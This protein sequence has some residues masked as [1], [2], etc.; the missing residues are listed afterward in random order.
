MKI[1]ILSRGPQLYST[2]SLV[3]A[4]F[5]KGHYVRVVD[6][7]ECN[8][9]LNKNNP[10][11]VY[12]SA[13]LKDID[14]IIPRI[15]NSGTFYGASV[16]QQFEMQD[17]YT[18]LTTDALLKARSKLRSMQLMSSC[19]IDMPRTILTNPLMDTGSI[20]NTIGVP[21]IIKLLSGT[22]GLGVILAESKK[23]GESVI[24][25]FHKLKE[26][27]IV[28]EFIKESKGSDIRAFVVDGKVV[29]AMKRQ[30]LPGEFRSNLH[31]GG[32]SE[33]ITL[34]E[35]EEWT[36]L[37]AVEILGLQ[38][39]GVD[40]LPSDRGPLLLE[41]NPSPGLEGIEKT[42]KVDIAGKIIE[43]IEKNA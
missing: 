23:T 30:A 28:Q 1:V 2:E 25:A 27:V 19:G 34:T 6:Y 10:E 29:A 43:M 32:S 24:D 20:V 18:T 40:M 35:R 16:V 15:G 37:K 26:R 11:I 14:A 21:L 7:M 5:R 22:H 31:R 39:A 8:V 33:Q 13:R 3:N 12:Q 4:G 9:I 17:I 42:T 38:V 41:V 36:V